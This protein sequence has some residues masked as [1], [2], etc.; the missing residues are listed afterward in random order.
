VLAAQEVQVPSQ[1]V[2]LL[3]VISTEAAQ[4]VVGIRWQVSAIFTVCRL[5]SD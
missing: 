5:D 4:V 1:N 2:S 3:L